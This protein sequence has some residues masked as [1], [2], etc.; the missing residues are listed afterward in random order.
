LVSSLD[1]GLDSC[2]GRRSSDLDLDRVRRNEYCLRL[3][4]I[5]RFR[6]EERG[7]HAECTEHGSGR[8]SDFKRPRRL[9]M[10]VWIG[11]YF[12]AEREGDRKSTRLNSS[13]GSISYAIF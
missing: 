9:G 2:P 6:P 5:V 1:R 13:H 11:D 8:M 10:Q 4:Q 12:E 3:D 7:V